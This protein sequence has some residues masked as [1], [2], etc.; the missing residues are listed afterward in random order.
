MDTPQ[1]A[2]PE[3]P[4]NSFLQGWEETAYLYTVLL[5]LN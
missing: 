3:K 4:N 1:L 5:N 2:E